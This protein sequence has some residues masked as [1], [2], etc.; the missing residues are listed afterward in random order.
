MDTIS[1]SVGCDSVITIDLNVDSINTAVQN[2]GDSLIAQDTGA[3]YQWVNCDNNST[4]IPG[5]TGQILKVAASGDYAVSLTK[6]GCID[7]SAC[8]N[9]IPSGFE[10][11][12]FEENNIIVYPNPNE[13]LFTIEH[14]FTEKKPFEVT[15]IN[16]KVLYRGT[17]TQKQT[18]VD[19]SN[20][21]TGIYLL[22]GEGAVVKL[23]LK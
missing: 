8:Y 6:H 5:E 19:L 15:N 10:T 22:R 7:T 20:F 13:G 3:T 17:L 16:G 1:N 21:A 23:V 9:V 2:S 4:P 18:K 14:S 11:A 12:I